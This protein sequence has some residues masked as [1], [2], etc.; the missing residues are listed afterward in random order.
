MISKTTKQITVIKQIL[1]KYFRIVGEITVRKI[2]A[3]S[4][5]YRYYK[6]L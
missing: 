6:R 3:I 2:I 1:E 4:R 5:E